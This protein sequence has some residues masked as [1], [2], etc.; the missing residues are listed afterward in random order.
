MQVAYVRK[1]ETITPSDFDG[2]GWKDRRK[3]VARAKS[4]AVQIERWMKVQA[5]RE[6]R[7]MLEEMRLRGMKALSEKRVKKQQDEWDDKMLM[8]IIRRYGVRQITDTGRDF[9]GSAW[10]FTPEKKREF[11]QEKIVQIQGVRR[12][13]QREMRHSVGV[14]LSDWLEQ[15]PNLSINEVSNRLSEWLT[16]SSAAE[17]PRALK[18]LGQRFTSHGMGARARM[19]AR[20]EQNQARNVGRV[21]SAR[22]LGVEYMVWFA[23][24]DGKSGER[25][26]EAMD[27]Q[28]RRVGEEFVNPL[29]GARL[30]YPG[31]QNAKSPFGVAGEIINCRCSVRPI[32]EEQA[33]RLGVL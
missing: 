11:L 22:D 19:I 8:A 4:M 32:T 6:L 28:V 15:D 14:A 29:T 5:K 18:P 31:D 9:A 10:V 24:N 25:H 2:E 17:T 20:T 12:S 26:H 13:L 3:T 7:R 27:K 21:E 23:N 1:E 16:V 30:R 33:R